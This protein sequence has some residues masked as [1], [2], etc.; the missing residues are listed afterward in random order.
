MYDRKGNYVGRIS[1][2]PGYSSSDSP[3]DDLKLKWAIRGALVGVLLAAFAV[4]SDPNTKGFSF[5]YSATLPCALLGWFIGL[6][7]GSLICDFRK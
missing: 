6:G 5:E 3:D 7:I 2:G 1:D 4:F